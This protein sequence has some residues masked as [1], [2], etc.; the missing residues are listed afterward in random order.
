LIHNDAADSVRS[1]PPCGEGWGVGVSVGHARRA[2]TTTP[3]PP[4]LAAVR[5]GD[6]PRKGEGRTESAACAELR[7]EWASRDY[8]RTGS[9]GCRHSASLRAFTP[10]FDGLWTR[11]NALMPRSR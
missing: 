4:A 5:R 7:T 8:A 10:V 3:T 6:P 9:A 1:P 11:V 2:T